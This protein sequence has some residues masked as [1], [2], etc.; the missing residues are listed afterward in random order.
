MTWWI[1]E[2]KTMCCDSPLDEY[3]YKSMVGALYFFDFFRLMENQLRMHTFVY[4]SI[5]ALENISLYGTFILFYEQIFELN[6]FVIT[7]VAILGGTFIGLL[8]MTIYFN[9]FK[10][11]Y[12]PKPS[13]KHVCT[14]SNLDTIENNLNAKSEEISNNLSIKDV[15]ADRKSLI[16]NIVQHSENIEEG[17]INTS[18][19]DNE[20][21]SVAVVDD[22]K[23]NVD[24]E[25]EVA[26]KIDN[27]KEEEK[28]E[29]QSEVKINV[30]TLQKRRAICSLTQLGL[31]PIVSD[32]QFGGKSFPVE[33][34]LVDPVDI[35]LN[36]D[37]KSVESSFI[38]SLPIKNLINEQG[39]RER[40]DTPEEKSSDNSQK[41]ETLSQMTSVHDYENLC[42][43]GVARPPWCIRS[44]QGYTDIENYV[45]DDSVVRDRRRDTLTSTVTGITMSSDFSDATYMTLNGRKL[46]RRTRQDDYLDTLAYDLADWE[47]NQSTVAPSD[48]D[49]VNL[50]TIYEEREDR[51]STSD[52]RSK[53]PSICSV[54]S[55]VATIDEIRKC[56]AENSPCHI[57]HRSESE[58]PK[59]KVLFPNEYNK[60][61]KNNDKLNIIREMT[62]YCLKDGGSGKTPLINAIL[63]DSPILGSKTDTQSC[64]DD[65]VE[66]LEDNVYVDMNAL[67][68]NSFG[69]SKIEEENILNISTESGKK[70][71]Y[72]ENLE[73]DQSKCPQSKSQ[74]VLSLSDMSLAVH[75]FTKTIDDKQVFST[76]NCSES[77]DFNSDKIKKLV[78]RP[79]R[80]FSLLR[81]RFEPK[82]EQIV[83]VV[84][85]QRKLISNR[86]QLNS[87]N[88]KISVIF[89]D[90][91]TLNSTVTYEKENTSNSSM[92]LKEKRSV[93]LKQVL[94]PPRFQSWS[95]KRIFSPN[96]KF[97]PKNN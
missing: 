6:I 48:L 5:M 29:A 51:S 71:I 10:R 61:V 1:A 95:K 80:K 55:L 63:S 70:N 66:L 12:K 25:I 4:Y 87:L 47:S 11:S 60:Y 13:N 40:L 83:C 54:S 96:S 50:G 90:P 34:N 77:N 35:S 27:V 52:L 68:K 26:M 94:T 64:C 73:L 72:K 65:Q 33:K 43:L 28:L 37:P 23:L 85:P 84:T 62:N 78:N 45:H 16:S 53:N 17:I 18:F 36:I 14:S 41:E 81:E 89:N 92:D 82:S 31:E 88:K 21:P 76:L 22:S 75:D 39:L 93:F 2:Q 56:T 15:T 42:P 97:A 86:P 3:A 19:I 59:R 49:V 44:W 9:I 20:E 57:Y 38:D 8:N 79:R 74:L 24:K 58:S 30:D 32:D 91:D 67:G 7:T 46:P 69:L